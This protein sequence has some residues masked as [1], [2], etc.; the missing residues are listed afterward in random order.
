MFINILLVGLG[1]F[2]GAVLRYLLTFIPVSNNFPVITL[3]INTVG[4]FVMGFFAG[5]LFGNTQIEKRIALFGQVGLCGGFTTF[6]A[7]SLEVINMF[8][9]NRYLTATVYSVISVIMCIGGMLAGRFI[10]SAIFQKG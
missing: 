1:G 8:E 3:V 9:E 4:G 2:L 6:S 7:M 5:M 10:S